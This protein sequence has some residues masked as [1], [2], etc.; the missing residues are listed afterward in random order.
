MEGVNH[1]LMLIR[2][3]KLQVWTWL[4]LLIGVG[5]LLFI[6]SSWFL[7]RTVYPLPYQDQVFYYSKKYGV[8]PYLVAGIMRVESS[9]KPRAESSRGARG[10]MQIMPETGQWAAEQIGL[11]DYDPIR[12]YD[13]EYNIQIGC[14]YLFNL[15]QEFR[16]NRLLVLAAYNAGS[17]RVQTWLANGQWDG[18][19]ET[20]ENIPY[21]ETRQYLK[22][23][24]NDYQIYQRLYE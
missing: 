15:N 20:I 23:V 18:H 17:G 19:W 21:P 9:F 10:L 8:D 1:Q 7:K 2:W 5:I 14:W 22:K 11:P 12:L 16:G 3:P 24:L 4:L 13:P 6:N